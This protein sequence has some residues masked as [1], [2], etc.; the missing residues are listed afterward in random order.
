VTEFKFESYEGAKHQ[1]AVLLHKY[2]FSERDVEFVMDATSY[3]GKQ[4]LNKEI[5]MRL[6]EC[7]SNNFFGYYTHDEDKNEGWIEA[8]EW[9]QELT[10]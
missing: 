1:L 9:L 7:E 2:K 4:A 5:K 6:T 10:Q 8:L 3:I